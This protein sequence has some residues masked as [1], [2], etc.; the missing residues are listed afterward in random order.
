MTTYKEDIAFDAVAQLIEYCDAA[1]T[2][3]DRVIF[4]R[5]LD[6]KRDVLSRKIRAVERKIDSETISGALDQERFDSLMDEL[7]EMHQTIKMVYNYQTP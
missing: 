5:I 3:K 2:P 1:P 6:R 4:E 7:S